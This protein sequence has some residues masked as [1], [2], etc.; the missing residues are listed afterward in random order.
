MEKAVP[1]KPR[2]QVHYT[3]LV[4][5]PFPRPPSFVDPPSIEWNASKD[6]HLWKLVSSRN[7]NINWSA[8]AAELNVSLPFLLQQAAWLSEKHFEGVRKQMQRLGV[9]TTSAALSPAIPSNADG[10]WGDKG[11]VIERSPSSLTV[12]Q[13]NIAAVSTAGGRQPTVTRA[14]RT[15]PSTREDEYIQGHE[16][17]TSDE[18]ERDDDNDPPSRNKHRTATFIPSIR[19]EAEDEDS[20]GASLPSENKAKGKR[21]LRAIHPPTEPSSDSTTSPPQST[22]SRPDTL[23]PR[24]RS[25]L[26]KAALSDGTT[27]PSMESSFSDLDDASVTQSA[28]EE[29]LLSNMQAGR[30]SMSIGS[31]LGSLRD[32]FGA[33]GR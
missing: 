24:H 21:K 17:P 12:T 3:V 22:A 8:T 5:L 32:V 13:G 16:E 20:S 1:S 29:A 6:A 7:P 9:T 10:G 14:V 25:Q 31:R 11:S 26:T 15:R 28:L 4:R 27:T 18:E 33:G 2:K 19:A 23:S 30:G